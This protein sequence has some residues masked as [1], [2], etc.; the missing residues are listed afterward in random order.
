MD[1]E[2]ALPVV[3]GLIP[4]CAI[5]IVGFS[6]VQDV[7]YIVCVCACSSGFVPVKHIQRFLTHVTLYVCVCTCRNRLFPVL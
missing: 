2:L 5:A 4:T 6:K 3:V 1:K 7:L